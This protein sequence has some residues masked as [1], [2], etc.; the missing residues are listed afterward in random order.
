VKAGADLEEAADAAVD[1]G[2]AGGGLGDAGEDFE[3]GAFTAA[4]AADDAEDF[5]GLDFEAQVIE[6]PEGLLAGVL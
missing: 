6:G 2:T 1:L 5:A 4:V 3:E